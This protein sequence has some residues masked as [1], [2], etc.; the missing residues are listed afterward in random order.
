M[1][2]K[3]KK[4]HNFMALCAH[5]PAKA[6]GKCPAPKVARDFLQADKGKAFNP[7]ARKV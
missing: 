1:P 3:T 4:Q 6:K 7:L 2:S 5:N